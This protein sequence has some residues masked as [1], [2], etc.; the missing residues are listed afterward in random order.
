MFA[1]TAKKR[2]LNRPIERYGSIRRIIST[3]T[4][5]QSSF[6]FLHRLI[7]TYSNGNIRQI[8][9][10]CCV[11]T[12]KYEVIIWPPWREFILFQVYSS[13]FETEFVIRVRR[14]IK[15]NGTEM[16]L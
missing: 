9:E 5:D 12:R 16:V 4:R 11:I 8:L 6:T 3:I 14:F 2:P 7:N 13:S 10:K 15:G 1:G